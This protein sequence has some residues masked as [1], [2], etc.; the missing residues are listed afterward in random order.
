MKALTDNVDGTTDY[1]S[2]LATNDVG[3]ITGDEGTDES[4]SGKNRDDE[5]GVAGADSTAG[6]G[7]TIGANGALNLL[8]EE[9]GVENTVDVTGVIT[10]GTYDQ[11]GLQP[12]EGPMLTRRRYHQR[13]QRRKAGRPSR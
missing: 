5:R 12:I 1:N 9:R 11:R 10:R 3:D 13:R 2:P 6:C 4:T 8:D 7:K